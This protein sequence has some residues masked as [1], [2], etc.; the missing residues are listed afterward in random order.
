MLH[1]T[2]FTVAG[3]LICLRPRNQ[4]IEHKDDRAEN[5]YQL[6]V[7][8]R[9]NENELWITLRIFRRIRNQMPHRPIGIVRKVQKYAKKGK[10]L[11]HRAMSAR[12]AFFSLALNV[13]IDIEDESVELV[14]DEAEIKSL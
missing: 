13:A 12:E 2:E 10:T 6:P 9:H 14:I 7:R 4:L 11:L 1:V 8:R 5:I 3:A